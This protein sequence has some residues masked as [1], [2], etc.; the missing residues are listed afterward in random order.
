MYIKNIALNIV[1][2]AFLCHFIYGGAISGADLLFL[3]ADFSFDAIGIFKY[4]N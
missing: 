1:L 3:R 4:S 2:R